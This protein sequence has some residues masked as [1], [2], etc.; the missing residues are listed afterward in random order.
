MS[1]I[2]LLGGSLLLAGCVGMYRLFSYVAALF[3]VAVLGT[4]SLERNGSELDLAPY[5]RLVLGLGT[6]F[7]SGL[8]GIWFGW[9][10]RTTD[11]T[12]LLGL[13]T[14]TMTYVVF[15]WLLPIFGAVYYALVFPS[16]GRR[17]IVDSILRDCGR[18]QR[19]TR[20]PLVPPHEHKRLVSQYRRGGHLP[21][22]PTRTGT[23]D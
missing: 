1:A 12:Y 20:Y 6:I 17:Q 13:P 14:S 7:F 16:T 15:L 9:H 21:G 23:T 5:S 8:T 10:L 2:A 11:Y 19:A 4:A 22:P 18:A 3:I